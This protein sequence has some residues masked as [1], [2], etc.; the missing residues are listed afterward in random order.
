[1]LDPIIY[2]IRERGVWVSVLAK[3][4]VGV[5]DWVGTSMTGVDG[6]LVI[7]TVFVWIKV[8]VIVDIV[9]VGVGK[10][11]VDI[12]GWIELLH[13]TNSRINIANN[14]KIMYRIFLILICDSF[15]CTSNTKHRE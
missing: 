8:R 6:E 3:I 13:P 9:C 1:L 5:L 4:G 11:I 14:Q 10:F 7:V 2:L 12:F 15:L